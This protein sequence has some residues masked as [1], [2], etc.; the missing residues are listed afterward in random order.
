MVN[1]IAVTMTGRLALKA[2]LQVLFDN[3]PA[4]D[5]VEVR[6]PAPASMPLGVSVPIELDDI[7]TIFTTAL[8]INID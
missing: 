2:S 1:S 7:D 8:V 4:F 6:G 3:Q 5:L